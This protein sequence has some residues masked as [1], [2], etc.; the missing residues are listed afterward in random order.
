MDCRTGYQSRRS[1]SVWHGLELCIDPQTDVIDIHLEPSNSVR[2]KVRS[3]RSPQSQ[4]YSPVGIGE[5]ISTVQRNFESTRTLER[6]SAG[7]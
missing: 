2:T 5:P 6:K 4:N 1:L 7:K 3:T